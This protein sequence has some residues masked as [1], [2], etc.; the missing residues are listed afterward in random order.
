MLV[1]KAIE[2]NNAMLIVE[3]ASIGWDVVTTIQEMGY[4][5]LYYAPKSELVGTQ[6]DLYVTKFDRGDGMVPGFSMNQRTRPLVIEKARS[7]MEEKSAL[8]RS[9]RLLDEWRVFIWKNGKPQ[10]LQGYN[11][12]LVMPYSIGLFLRDTALRFR[13]TAMD[14]T[15]ASLNGYTKTEQNFQVY[16]PNNAA[17]QQNPW[18]MNVNGQNDD[19][20]WLLG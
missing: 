18:S 9:Q 16:T 6:I 1:S 5:N 12:D 17:N 20:T 19:I 2:W 4:P 7:F 15:Y 11:D 3:N 8:I 10:A 13:Q 14:L